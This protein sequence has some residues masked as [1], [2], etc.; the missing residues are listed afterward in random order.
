MPSAISAAVGLVVE[1]DI[2]RHDG[3]LQRLAGIGDAVDRADELAHDLRPLGVAEIEIV[4]Q[5]QRPRPHCREIAPSLGHG[6][7][8]A[9]EGISL[10]IARRHVGRERERLRPVIDAHHRGV[11]AGPLHGIAQ[12][13][14][15]VLLP[16]P[17]PRAQIG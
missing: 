10:A 6:L 5:R 15:V 3:K 17:A 13:H 2:A 1:R 8:A 4:R 9:F 11:A 7:L 16:H 12:D 14:V